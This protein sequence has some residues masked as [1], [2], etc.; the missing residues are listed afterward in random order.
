VV[1]LWGWGC[2]AWGLPAFLPVLAGHTELNQTKTAGFLRP[3][4]AV[5]LA[6]LDRFNCASFSKFNCLQIHRMR[7]AQLSASLYIAKSSVDIAI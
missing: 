2:G 7:F 6:F 3:A 5:G 4:E 1:R